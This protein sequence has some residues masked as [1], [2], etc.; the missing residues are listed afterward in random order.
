MQWS[1]RINQAYQRLRDPLKRAAY[2]CE[3]RGAPTEAENNT[4]MTPAFLMQQIAWREALDDAQGRPTS[5]RWSNKF[6]PAERLLC[7]IAPGG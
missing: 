5:R 4:A 2:L 3:L 6:G 7:A 1:S